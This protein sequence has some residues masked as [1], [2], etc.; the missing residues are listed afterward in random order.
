LPSGAIAQVLRDLPKF[1]S[2]DLLRGTDQFDDAA[3]YRINDTTALVLTLDFFPPLVD[4]PSAFGR[5]AAANSLSDVYAMGAMPLVAL[6][7]VG[8]PDNKLPAE[9][10]SEILCGGAERVQAAGAVI[11]GGHSVRDAE[12]KY[13]LSVTGTIHPD[14]IISNGGAQVGDVLVLTKPIGS[15]VLTTAAK[16]GKIS[17]DDLTEAIN[18]MVELNAGACKAM[19]EAGVHAATDITGFGLIGH[20][21]EMATASGVTLVIEA[22]KV[23]LLVDTIRLAEKKMLTRAY[24]SNLEHIGGAFAADG[25]DSTLVNVLSD[26]QTSGG[27]LI[28][29]PESN[30]DRLKQSLQ[31]ERTPSAAVIGTAAAQSERSVTL[32]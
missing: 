14:R 19:L 30:V 7:I 31:R 10:L 16:A 4:D 32:R 29:V 9:I 1:S 3:V 22:A 21:H 20:A 17:G 5:I 24:K 8:F 15:G 2:A 28:A 6:N 12:I 13:G 26:A 27:L 25:V 23:P 11:A 18:V